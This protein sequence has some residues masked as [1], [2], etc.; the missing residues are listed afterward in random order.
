[1][2]EPLTQ[3]NTEQ[4]LETLAH[5]ELRGEGFV[6]DCLLAEVLDAGINEPDYLSASGE[7]PNAF[8]Q[9]E[10]NAWANYHIRQSKKVM[11]VYGGTVR[12]SHIADTP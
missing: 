11:N 3:T 12:R 7:D 1:M 8:F 6:T 2:R 10:P 9:G 5:V 4:I